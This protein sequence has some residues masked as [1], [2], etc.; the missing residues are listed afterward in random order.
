MKPKIEAPPYR[1]TALRNG[2][3]HAHW[4]RLPRTLC[5][6]P[7]IDERDAWPAVARCRAC[8]DISLVDL[9][10]RP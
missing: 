1:W 10:T 3:A 8:E 7:A 6:L 5:G 2:I 4:K 9:G